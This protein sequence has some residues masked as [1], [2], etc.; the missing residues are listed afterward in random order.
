MPPTRKN[1][2]SRYK[3]TARYEIVWFPR[4]HDTE[5]IAVADVLKSATICGPSVATQDAPQI[6]DD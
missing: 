2:I 5:P 6:V 4:S 3:N 1:L